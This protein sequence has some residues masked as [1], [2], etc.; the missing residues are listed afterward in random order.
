[1]IRL[2]CLALALAGLAD[3]AAAQ[4]AAS[5]VSR[6]GT[7]VSDLY[8]VISGFERSGNSVTVRAQQIKSGPLAAQPMTQS[9]IPPFTPVKCY[10]RNDELVL[11]LAEE[12]QNYCGWVPATALLGGGGQDDAASPFSR[13]LACPT[14]KPL[15]VSDYCRKKEALGSYEALCEELRQE[16]GDFQRNPIETKFLTWNADALNPAERTAVTRY[17]EPDRAQALAGDLSI[18]SVF[19]VWDVAAGPDGEDLF[20]LI[21]PDQKT[22]EGWVLEQSGTVWFSRLTTFFN[23]GS[24]API[25]TEAPG[26]TAAEPLAEVPPNLAA[27]LSAPEDFDKYPVLVDNRAPAA[28]AGTTQKPH[29]EIAFIGAR[30]GEG[31]LCSTP[32]GERVVDKIGLLDAVDILFVIDATASMEAYFPIVAEEV[33]EIALERASTTNRFGAVL[34]GDFLDRRATAPGDPMQIR[35]AVDLTE[36]YSGDEFEPL[37]SQPLFIADALGD[38]PEAAFAA[39]EQAIRAADWRDEGVRIVVHLADHGDRAEAPESLVALMQAQNVLYV[40]I[41]VRGDFITQVNGAFAAQT[42]RLLDRSRVDGVPMGI[43]TQVTYDA[44][45]AQ[46]GDEARLRIRQSLRGATEL[47]DVISTQIASILLSGEESTIAESN[48]YPPGYAQLVAAARKIYG[49]DLDDVQGSAEAR[50]LAAKGYVEVPPQG[51]SEDW[52]FFAA[53]SPREVKLLADQFDILCK[54][55][56]DSGA[57]ADLSGALREV[58]E[59]LTGDVLSRD[60][61]LYFAY[62]DNRDDIPLVNRTIL[63]E[64]ILDLGQDLNSFSSATRDKVESYRR[65]TCRTRKLLQLIDSNYRVDRPYETGPDGAPGD[66]AWDEAEQDYDDLRARKFTWPRIGIG[67][68]QTVYL[69]LSYLPRPYDEIAVR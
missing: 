17:A 39:V 63:G 1:M 6:D 2:A 27:M 38:R 56:H 13:G 4:N 52:E 61:A 16:D 64:G 51:D 37:L 32:G 47:Q 50:T 21:G 43:D 23:G 7:C 28:I 69:P 57:E 9:V 19:K 67:N 34:Y 66:L 36:I 10:A 12:G 44:N 35:T 8:E 29:L 59:I 48:R 11:I 5:F 62:F 26:T 49:I 3:T 20:V 54:S 46:T 55:M 24:N 31:Q 40:P 65:E 53:I 18:F 68:V 45:G 60:N 30:C 14:L 25:L 22:V 15:Q 41:A 58:I 33:A 42:Q